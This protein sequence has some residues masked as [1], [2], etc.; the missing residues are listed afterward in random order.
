MKVHSIFVELYSAILTHGDKVRVIQRAGQ[1]EILLYRACG[2]LGVRYN[3]SS[4]AWLG[5]FA[6]RKPRPK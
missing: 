4:P 1:Y 2:G 5:T 6:I 3:L